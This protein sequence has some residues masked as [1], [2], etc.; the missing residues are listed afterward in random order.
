MKRARIL[1]A[2]MLTLVVAGRGWGD[3]QPPALRDTLLRIADAA[4][5]IK[6]E[7]VFNYEHVPSSGSGFFVDEDGFVLTNWHVVAD[8]IQGYLWDREREVTAK[9]LELTVVVNSGSPE[10]RELPARIVARD[11]ERDLALLQVRYHPTAFLDVF[12]T[13]DVAVGDEIWLA[14]FP[15]GDLL[16]WDRKA[17]ATDTPSPAVSVNSGHVTSRRLDRTGALATIQFD[18]SV[19]PGN[20]GG[21]IVNRDGELIGVVFAAINGGEGLGFGVPPNLIREFIDRQA[22]Q[23]SFKPGVVLSPP[24]PIRVEVVPVMVAASRLRGE[25]RFEGDDIPAVTL[26][27]TPTDSGLAAT[28]E[29]PDR[30]EG[31]AVPEKYLAT[32]SLSTE[33]SARPLARRFAIHAVPDTVQTLASQREPDRMMEDRKLLA[34]EMGLEDFAKSQPVAAGE[35]RRTTLADAAKNIK[36]QRD[37]SGSVVVDNR[38]VKEIAGTTA[39]PRRYQQLPQIELRNLAERLDRLNQQYQELEGELRRLRKSNGDWGV[40]REIRDRA[41]EVDR[42]RDAVAAELRERGVVLCSKPE[43]YFLEGADFSSTRLRCSSHGRV[44]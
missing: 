28:I 12:E 18:A 39:D 3:D 34:G 11:R 33:G 42:Q 6:A 1:A 44:R 20:S 5:Y 37:A 40:Q 38:A 26:P 35:G 16:A 41:Y 19:N 23:I 30:I 2:G 43:F 4:V 17:E 14:G 10:E 15:F 25:V 21:P 36:L 27:L 13:G 29:L 24:A 8:Q 31:V 7:R 22:V 9:V 32:V